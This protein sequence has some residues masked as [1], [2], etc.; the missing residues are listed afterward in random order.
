MH[1]VPTHIRFFPST[2]TH[3]KAAAFWIK[4]RHQEALLR[5]DKIPDRPLDDRDLVARLRR[6]PLRLAL[7]N[8]RPFIYGG[9]DG[10]E[11]AVSG[12]DVETWEHVAEKLGVGVSYSHELPLKMAKLVSCWHLE[13]S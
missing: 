10:T 12:F 13:F 1:V 7:Y 8:F 2:H 4:R 5:R 3:T 6:S 11:A 9:T